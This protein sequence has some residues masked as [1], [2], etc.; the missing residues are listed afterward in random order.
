M[1]ELCLEKSERA[2]PIKGGLRLTKEAENF[3]VAWGDLKMAA[4]LKVTQG[5]LKI[6]A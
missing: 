1:V 5:G 2:S 3:R 4:K 6:A